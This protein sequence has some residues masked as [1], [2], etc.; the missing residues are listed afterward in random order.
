MCMLVLKCVVLIY[1]VSI[2]IKS[3]VILVMKMHGADDFL[4]GYIW[5]TKQWTLQSIL[6]MTLLIYVN[7]L[8]LM[9]LVISN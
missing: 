9:S 5:D 8:L 6:D 1:A 3:N 2:M 7:V 4:C